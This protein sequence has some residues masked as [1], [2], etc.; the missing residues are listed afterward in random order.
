MKKICRILKRQIEYLD[1]FV[2][3]NFKGKFVELVSYQVNVVNN[4]DN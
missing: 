4:L 2:V 1:I 3:L